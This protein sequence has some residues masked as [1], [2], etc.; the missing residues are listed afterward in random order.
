MQLYGAKST[1]ANLM[2]NLLNFFLRQTESFFIFLLKF[3]RFIA[4]LLFSYAQTLN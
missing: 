1:L 3:G 4:N 2:S